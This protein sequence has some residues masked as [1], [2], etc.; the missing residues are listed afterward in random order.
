MLRRAKVFDLMET[1]DNLNVRLTAH[2]AVCAERYSNIMSRMNR[3]EKIMLLT[4][5]ALIVG[6]IKTFVHI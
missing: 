3:I 5:G 4:A 6:L 2:E 1:I